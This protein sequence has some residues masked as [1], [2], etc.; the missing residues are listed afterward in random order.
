MAQIGEQVDFY[1]TMKLYDDASQD[2]DMLID[3]FFRLYFGSAAAPMQAFYTLIETTYSDPAHWDQ[4]GGHHQ[5]EAIAW[6]R[7]G[8]EA[9]MTQLQT[10]IQ[11]AESLA[12]TPRERERV[13]LWKNGVWDYMVEGRRAYLE[14]TGKLTKGPGSTAKDSRHP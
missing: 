5:T 2:T 13:A 4:N 6:E 7:L 3:E 8:T 1:V 9:V 12:A 10:H 11:Q 14:K